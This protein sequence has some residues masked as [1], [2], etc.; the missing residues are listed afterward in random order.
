MISII[1]FTQ[2]CSYSSYR[3]TKWKNFATCHCFKSDFL[4]HPYLLSVLLFFFHHA[5]W[6]GNFREKTL[7]TFCFEILNNS[8]A[9]IWKSMVRLF[10]IENFYQRSSYAINVFFYSILV[11]HFY[12]GSIFYRELCILW[13]KTTNTF[14]ESSRIDQIISTVPQQ[15]TTKGIITNP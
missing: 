8:R 14:L 15:V 4:L 9:E 10:S 1:L 5:H 12:C 13:N 7:D 3:Q 2:N 6:E 11:G